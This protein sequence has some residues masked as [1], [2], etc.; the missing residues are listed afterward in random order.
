MKFDEIF[1]T[2]VGF[3]AHLAIASIF[4]LVVLACWHIRYAPQP[5]K[6][7][8]AEWRAQLEEQ[9]ASA[10]ARAQWKRLRKKHGYPTGVIYEPDRTPYYFCGKERKEKCKFM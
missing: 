9:Q 1:D 8:N 4:V 2:V 10:E 3:L 6:I 5:V 7:T